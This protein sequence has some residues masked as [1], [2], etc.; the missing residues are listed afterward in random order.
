MTKILIPCAFALLAMGEPALADTHA[1]LAESIG[2]PVYD[3][4]DMKIGV[5]RGETNET[6]TP[7][8]IVTALGAGP[9][10][11]D[12]LIAEQDLQPRDNGGWL[13]MLDAGSIAQLQPYV[14][15]H[16]PPS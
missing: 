3:N 2:Q 16:M 11:H 8:A 14:P 6:G 5:L 9:G 1:T 13:S 12:V 4:Q 15:G 10:N 7:S